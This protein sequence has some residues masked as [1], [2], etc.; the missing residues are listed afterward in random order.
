MEPHVK[1][2][3]Q[4]SD[5]FPLYK[6]VGKN[7]ARLYYSYSPPMADFISG[8][9]SLRMV[10]RWSLLPFAGI[11]WGL[12]RFGFIPTPLFILLISTLV[13]ISV[14]SPAGYMNQIC[15]KKFFHKFV[16]KRSRSGVLNDLRF[17]LGD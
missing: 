3:R 7:F 4:F 9:E 16:E 1:L 15:N 12:L 2:L 5:R 6:A 13:S 10:V 11:S 17:S 8:H 14:I